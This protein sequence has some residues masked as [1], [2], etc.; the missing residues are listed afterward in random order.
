MGKD[1]LESPA[2]TVENETTEMVEEVGDKIEEKA[3]DISASAGD[4]VTSSIASAKSSASDALEQAKELGGSA[5]GVIREGFGA[6]GKWK[7]EGTP[8]RE[9]IKTGRVGL[10]DVLV[11]ARTQY[12]GLEESVQDKLATSKAHTEAMLGN[13]GI[14]YDGIVELRRKHPEMLVGGATLAVALPSV[15]GGKRALLRNGICAFAAS[16]AV[17]YGMNWW[18]TRRK[19]QR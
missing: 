15:L 16:G 10:N 11:S 17:V 13:L 3:K 4:T 5:T 1:E 14:E 9:V 7:D 6:M 12:A 19:A 8:L 2:S 18:E